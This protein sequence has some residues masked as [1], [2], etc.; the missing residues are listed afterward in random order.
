MNDFDSIIKRITVTRLEPGDYTGEDGILYCG[1]CRTPKQ[2]RM[3]APPM[4]GRLLPHP[5]RC[6]QERLDR[7]AEEQEARRHRQAVADL[8]SKGFTDPAMREWTFANDNGKCL[9][10]KHA[11]FYVDNWPTI[12]AENIGYLLWG[13]VGTG[14]S[15]F[16]GCIANA[17][18]EQEVAVRMTNFAL[19]LNDLTASFEGRNEYIAR[20]CRA[21]LLI[22]DDFGMERGTEYGLEQVY[23]VID[24]RYRSRRPLIVTTNLSLQDLQHPQDTAHARIY[25]RLLE[26]CAPI[27]FSGENF[28]KAT[29]QDKLARLK[30]L[31][32]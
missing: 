3:E 19:I 18:M 15:Y 2:F 32:D 10:M 23:N 5:C 29:A 20:L 11:H 31:M 30:N 22:L 25:D 21:P 24:S 14:K 6:E 17:L 9:Q 13:G 27:R 7:E 1:K 16:A 8:K 28:R 4:K 12:R 26:M